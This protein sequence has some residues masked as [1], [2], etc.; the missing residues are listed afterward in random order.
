MALEET[1]VVV[2][3]SGF[4]GS[5]AAKRFAERGKRVVVLERGGR[6][7]RD[8]FEA[9]R[10]FF[11]KPS[12]G[13]YGFHELRRRGRTIVPWLGAAIGGG[14][15]VYAGTLKRLERWDGFPSAIREADMGPFAAR[16]EHVMQAMPFPDWEPYASNRATRLM[17]QAGAKLQR[18][19]PEL[20]ESWGPVNL[21]VSFA[22]RGERPGEAFVNVHGCAQRTFDPNEQALLGGD[23]DAKNT[24]DKNYLFLAECA[25]KPAD[26]RAFAEADRIERCADGRYIVEYL[27]RDP[28]NA[29]GSAA[30]KAILARHV[31]VAA[32]AIGSTELL[33]RNRD[34]HHTLER[35]SPALG[36]RYTTNGNFVTLM[37]P[38]RGFAASWGGFAAMAI[39]L[40]RRSP[41]LTLAG[42]LVYYGGLFASDPPYDA[43][44]G[45]TNSDNIR[46]RGRDGSL[47]GA[48]IE[49]GRYP[50]PGGIVSAFLM[51][52]PP[53]SRFPPPAY[54]E[55][56]FDG[57]RAS[58]SRFRRSARSRARGP[59][60]FSAWV[61]TTRSDR[62]GSMPRVV[63]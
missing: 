60:R 17:Y 36:S 46:F 39:G 33:L 10:H 12:R 27:V 2:I 47:D 20:V 18:S 53:C 43:D 11:F 55:A 4:G 56:P 52:A 32:G 8:H 38:F 45:T 63:S 13:D 59:F 23:I 15:H 16:V 61:A 49:S 30:G 19:H 51:S 14:S 34:V 5:V 44:A 6:V 22:R 28:A 29:P 62:C 40:G 41:A 58:D 24:L 50:T 26:V 42:A 3:G 9:D 48:F 57:R 54:R 35:L 37:L 1:D 21:A 7:T 31:V 25:A